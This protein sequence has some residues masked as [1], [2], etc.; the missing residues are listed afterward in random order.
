[1][2][3]GLGRREAETE[4][5]R[6]RPVLAML[7]GSLEVLC[8]DM[9]NDKQIN[10]PLCPRFLLALDEVNDELILCIRGTFGGVFTWGHGAVGSRLKRAESR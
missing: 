3:F 7:G 2:T 5:E 9:D 1:M 10:D 6:L 4:E 8:S